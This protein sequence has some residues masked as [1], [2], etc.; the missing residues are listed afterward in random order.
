MNR[1][2]RR[3]RDQDYYLRHQKRILER[4][5][6]YRRVNRERERL[7]AK[8]ARD[9]VKARR[10]ALQEA[11]EQSDA[12]RATPD[13]ADVLQSTRTLFSVLLGQ[14]VICGYTPTGE[15]D[16]EEHLARHRRELETTHRY[17]IAA[18]RR[19]AADTAALAAEYAA[20]GLIESAIAARL[21][22]T[23]KQLRRQLRRAAARAD[24]GD[25]VERRDR[26]L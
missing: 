25:Q 8:A 9:A 14:C 11:F 26:A 4:Q 19:S 12:A 2:L 6:E 13:D 3:E 7:R 17:R 10:G 21:D 20:A 1:Q 15:D 5:A 16:R 23:V 24:A 18:K 22:I